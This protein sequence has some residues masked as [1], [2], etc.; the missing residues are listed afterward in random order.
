MIASSIGTGGRHHLVHAPEGFNR[1]QIRHFV[2]MCWAT[3]DAIGRSCAARRYRLGTISP[4]LSNC[5]GGG[6]NMRILSFL[7]PSHRISALQTACALIWPNVRTP[8]TPFV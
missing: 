8:L 2:A 6:Q 4:L 1:I 5:V 7:G 3:L